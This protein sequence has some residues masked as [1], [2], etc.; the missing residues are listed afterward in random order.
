[1]KSLLEFLQRGGIFLNWMV[2]WIEKKKKNG[3]EKEL[4][5]FY[6]NT[7]ILCSL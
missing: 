5:I 4:F 3:N 7:N 6:K 1:M 2:G